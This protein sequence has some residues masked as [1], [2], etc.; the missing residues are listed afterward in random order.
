MG[1]KYENGAF[2]DSVACFTEYMH[3]FGKLALKIDLL[4][5][6]GAKA[7]SM[8]FWGKG[9]GMQSLRCH[10]SS[11]ICYGLLARLS[12]TWFLLLLERRAILE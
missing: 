10:F 12:K 7:F 8:Q 2:V 6:S 3:V 9:I 5:N 11:A 1:Q 4:E